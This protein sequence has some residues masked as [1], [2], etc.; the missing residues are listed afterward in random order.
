MPWPI[1]IEI[2]FFVCLIDNARPRQSWTL[3]ERYIS[4]FLFEFFMVLWLNDHLKEFSLFGTQ[5]LRQSK[6]MWLSMLE[7]NKEEKRWEAKSKRCVTKTQGINTRTKLGRK[8]E[9]R[10]W[11][12]LKPQYICHIHGHFGQFRRC[13]RF[14]YI[15]SISLLT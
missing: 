15:I 3:C 6:G 7:K 2:Y 13:K 11:N 9:K 10:H 14:I 12:H 4:F 1:C 8:V 5:M